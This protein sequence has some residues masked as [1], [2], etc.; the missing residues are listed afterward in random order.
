MTY[1]TRTISD[2]I[3]G[4]IDNMPDNE[5]DR[6]IKRF[7]KINYVLNTKDAVCIITEDYF[8]AEAFEFVKDLKFGKV[9]KSGNIL[10]VHEPLNGINFI[11]VVEE[12]VKELIK[13]LEE[14]EQC[15]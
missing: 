15:C 4:D 10:F 6:D 9:Y 8:D 12:E 2:L 3:Y 14:L 5:L 13:K 11:Y 1:S 7:E